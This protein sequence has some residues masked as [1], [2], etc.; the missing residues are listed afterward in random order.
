[1]TAPEASDTPRRAARG[2][3]AGPSATIDIVSR[4]E[5]VEAN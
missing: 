2:K 5:R 4:I 3:E 1:M